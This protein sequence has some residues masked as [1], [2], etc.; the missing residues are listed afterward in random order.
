VHPSYQQTLH[1]ITR[2]P[3]VPYTKTAFSFQ[4]SPGYGTLW[5]TAHGLLTVPNVHTATA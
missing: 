5:S 1:V 2:S 4:S 3:A